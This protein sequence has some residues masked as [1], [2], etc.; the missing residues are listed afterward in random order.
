MSAVLQGTIENTTDATRGQ[1]LA[2]R[3]LARKS[4]LEDALADCGRHEAMRRTALETALA[5][6]YALITGDLAHPPSVIAR[7]LNNW[8]ERNKHL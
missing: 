7:A 3:V 8:L 1:P 2:A 5:G 4:E 6:C